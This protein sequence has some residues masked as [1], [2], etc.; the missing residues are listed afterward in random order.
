MIKENE[1]IIP[2][3]STVNVES[4]SAKQIGNKSFQEFLTSLEEFLSKPPEYNSITT[5]QHLQFLSAIFDSLF[6]T[7]EDLDQ[8]YL[9]QVNFNIHT[10]IRDLSA[11][12]FYDNRIVQHDE[13][14]LYIMEND[15]VY[16]ITQQKWQ[17]YWNRFKK[18][19]TSF[20]FRTE[21]Y[22]PD[23]NDELEAYDALNITITINFFLEKIKLAF[24]NRLDSKTKSLIDAILVE[25]QKL[26][27]SSNSNLEDF[28]MLYFEINYPTINST[29]TLPIFETTKAKF[30][31]K[32]INVI[33]QKLNELITVTKSNKI[34]LK[35]LLDKLS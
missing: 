34:I 26:K 14:G 1:K 25:L 20:L 17:E 6:N 35:I 16:Q 32:E 33:I 2:L 24:Y 8:E 31:Q 23:T 15:L 29:T 27:S 5:T 3:S 4:H 11:I 10:F 12:T 19:F 7:V 21:R 28:L 9:I 22:H 18:L 13:V 30:N